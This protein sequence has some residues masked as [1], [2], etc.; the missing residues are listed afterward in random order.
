LFEVAD[1]DPGHGFTALD[2]LRPGDSYNVVEHLISNEISTGQLLLGRLFPH[3]GAFALSGMAAL[4]DAHATEQIKE[5][6]DQGKLKPASIIK[7]MDG[8]ELENLF[9]RSI[10]DAARC[11]NL[12]KIYR[13]LHRY[14]DTLEP[15]PVSFDE[16]RIQIES[17]RD[18][19]QLAADLC[20]Q[21]P[22]FCRHEMDLLYALVSAAWHKYH[23]S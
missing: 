6:I 15:T 14:L 12:E 20:Q 11:H 22:V 1:I 9:G 18:P 8:L 21:I 23:N 19:L 5:F 7:D 10:H 16:L 13:R 17:C 2:L 4:M 3:R